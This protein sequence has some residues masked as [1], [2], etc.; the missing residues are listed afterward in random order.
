MSIITALRDY[1][2]I[3]KPARKKARFLNLP[4]ENPF[5]ANAADL[6]Q[7]ALPGSHRTNTQESGYLSTHR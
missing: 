6:W 5:A 1:L 3:D 2:V 4:I 7:A